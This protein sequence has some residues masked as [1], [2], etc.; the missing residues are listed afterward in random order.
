MENSMKTISKLVFSAVAALATMGFNAACYAVVESVDLPCCTGDACPTSYVSEG[1]P[2]VQQSARVSGIKIHGITV[3]REGMPG[4]A[5]WKKGIVSSVKAGAMPKEQGLDL[6]GASRTYVTIHAMCAGLPATLVNIGEIGSSIIC[7]I[8]V[9]I[10]VEQQ[11]PECVDPQTGP[12]T[13]VEITKVSLKE[14]EQE[15]KAM[16]ER[17]EMLRRQEQKLDAEYAANQRRIETNTKTLGE[18][19]QQIVGGGGSSSIVLPASY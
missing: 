10:E 12:H 6:F 16:A 14:Q 11:F 15:L 3:P 8:G 18:S 4:Y 2:E 7:P 5:E 17:I 9:G 13:V 1:I 19:W